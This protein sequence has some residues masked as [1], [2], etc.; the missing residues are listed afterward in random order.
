MCHTAEDCADPRRS[1][2][3]PSLLAALSSVGLR[4]ARRGHRGRLRSGK[5]DHTD[6]HG[7]EGHRPHGESQRVRGE[8]L[9]EDP[10]TERDTHDRVHD[11]Q[12][13]LGNTKSAQGTRPNRM[14]LAVTHAPPAPTM[15][16]GAPYGIAPAVPPPQAPTKIAAHFVRRAAPHTGGSGGRPPGIIRCEQREDGRRPSNMVNREA[17]GVGFEPTRSVTR[18][19]GFQDRRHRPLGEPSCV[20]Q[21]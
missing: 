14:R 1:A 6:A 4:T 21:P 10:D 3:E 7:S 15:Y 13:W 18:P 19:S 12:Q 17:E 8:V 9:L 5:H 20:H 2:Q 16:A 11:H